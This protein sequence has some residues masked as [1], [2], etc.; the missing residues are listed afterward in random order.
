MCGKK[1]AGRPSATEANNMRA[2]IHYERRE[3]LVTNDLK[4]NTFFIQGRMKRGF[5]VGSSH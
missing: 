4:E 2:M 1:P 5:Y 3:M